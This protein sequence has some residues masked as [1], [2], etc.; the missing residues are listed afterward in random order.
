M[1]RVFVTQRSYGKS[2]E[3]AKQFGELN[4]ILRADET[5]GKC[6]SNT[7][8]RKLEDALKDYDP[9]E[10]FLLNIGAPHATGQ[11]YSLIMEQTNGKITL[12]IWMRRTQEYVASPIDVDW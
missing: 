9:D 2:L 12:L 6:D 10:D 3:P 1:G 11:A 4:V 5:H 7:I 8:F